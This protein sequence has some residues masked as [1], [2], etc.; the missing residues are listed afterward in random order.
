MTST[1]DRL[2]GELLDLLTPV[3][4]ALDSPA[5]MRQLLQRLGHDPS[6]AAVAEAMAATAATKQSLSALITTLGDKAWASQPLDD[7]DHTRIAGDVPEIFL[8]VRQLPEVLDAINLGP[9]FATEIVD[10][11][12]V[13]YLRFRA[14]A[15]LR[16]L[17]L[18]GVLEIEVLMP[19]EGEGAAAIA[20][21]RYRFQWDRIRRWV[22]DPSS[23]MQE[24]YAWGRTEFAADQLLDNLA[25]LSDELGVVALPRDLPTALDDVL[26]DHGGLRPTG[27][28]I[29]LHRLVKGDSVDVD[30]S[31]IAFPIKGSLAPVDRDRG[32]AIM[33]S[34][35]AAIE[36]ALPVSDDGTWVMYIEA[37]PD[38]VG[39][40][41][42]RIHPSGLQVDMLDSTIP[43]GSFRMEVAKERQPDQATIL[44]IGDSGGSRLEAN[45]VSFGVGGSAEGDFYV[46]VAIKGL[47]L[48]LNASGDGLLA[49]IIPRPIELDA[50]DVVAGWRPGRGIYIEQGSALTL[51]IPLDVS[52]AGVVRVHELGLRLTLAQGASLTTLVSAAASIG[53][54]TLA[55]A[56]LGLEFR[57]TE[58]PEGAFGVLDLD[59][60]I[61]FPSGYA[62]ALETGPIAGGGALFR[63][64]HEYRGVLALQFET[65]GFSA[66]AILTTQLPGGRD[67][68]SFLASVFGEFHIP[69]GYGFFLTG[70]G[71]IIG[72]NRRADSSALRELITRGSLDNLLFPADPVGQAPR[73]LDALADVFPAAEGVHIFGPVARIVFGRPTLVEGKLGLVIEVGDQPRAL[74]LGLI[75]SDLPNK[76]T[77]LVS[78]RVSFFGE[79][80]FAA[81]T[82]SMD[83]ALNPGSRVLTYAIS[84]EMAARTGW[85]PRTDHVISFGGLHPAYP[86]PA[87]FP[88]LSRLSINFGTNNPRVTLS[89]YLAVTANSLQFGAMASLYAKGPDVFLVGQL[90]AEGELY[91]HALVYFDPFAFDA[92]LGG[93]LSLL[94][95]GDVVLSLGFDLRLSGPNPFR[96]AG[97]VWATV[98]GYDVGFGVEHDWGEELP[99]TPP[100]TDPITVLRDAIEGGAGVEPIP[101]TTRVS[102]VVF[103]PAA[104]DAPE[105]QGVVDPA[106]GVHILQRAVPLGVV[107]ERLGEAALAGGAHRYDLAVLDPVGNDLPLSPAVADFVRGHFWALGEE[108]RLRAPAF[109]EHPAGLVLGGEDLVVNPGAGVDAEY[110][111]EV[112]VLQPRGGSTLPP[113][114]VEDVELADA[115]F[116]RW[117]AVHRRQVAQPLNPEAVAGV[118]ESAVSIRTTEYAPIGGELD[119]V[120]SLSKVLESAPS[121]GRTAPANPAVAAYVVAAAA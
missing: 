111:Y 29:P 33:P 37:G 25:R 59:A 47:R 53:P 6:A 113:V 15:I 88:D 87:N 39:G 36:A 1:A 66:M 69:L 74:I 64:D 110:G 86:R 76:D 73:I 51:R 55:F 46:A 121:R 84:G 41:V 109:E 79:I 82:I 31:L 108:E 4:L 93:H 11:L 9:S 119:L 18:L 42:F 28:E 38:L 112:I 23:L 91:L 78:L 52:V 85:A 57:L 81:G 98:W 70:L 22:D 96:V 58:N 12:I 107:I 10:L 2:T 34:V 83:A 8:A 56:D 80:N 48:V 26:D 32:I 5:G 99:L 3:F 61:Q 7:A 63:K 27:V 77:A 20:F 118:G 89:A 60:G 17:I 114:V 97:R 62:V 19:A 90:A 105:A 103:P 50:G 75:S 68:F 104:V 101:S 92:K 13:D 106:A 16:G 14:P 44:I 102:G 71:G 120:A 67:G 95:D 35:G 30:V 94:V 49:Q 45:G 115:E 116:A 54:L 65:M 72:I 117:S 100:T 40:M 21:E 24:V 43:A